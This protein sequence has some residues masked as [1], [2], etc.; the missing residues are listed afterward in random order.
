MK[1]FDD[2]VDEV[3][4]SEQLLASTLGGWRGLVES[5]APTLV[6]ILIFTFGGKNL[7]PALIAALSVGILLTLIRLIRRQTL[8][9]VLS[10]L[11]GLLIAAWFSSRTGK[12]ED[13]FLPGII[14]NV[15][16]AAAFLASILFRFPLVG[17]IVGGLQGDLL[18]WRKDPAKVKLFTM[19]TWWWVG[20]YLFRVVVQYP[21]Y[22]AKQVEILGTI[23]IVMGWPLYIAVTYATFRAV[24][25]FEK[26]QKS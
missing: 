3:A 13:F 7:Q 5:A 26:V 16:Y 15:S 14:T 9:Q 21:L 6:F 1:E 10:G 12:A 19:L 4:A 24:M 2:R 25:N 11:F 8:Q 22:L 18:G 17:F 20:S 23:K